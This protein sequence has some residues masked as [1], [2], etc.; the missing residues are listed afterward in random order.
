MSESDAA[1]IP[2]PKRLSLEQTGEW[3][4]QGWEDFV[5]EPVLGLIFGGIYPLVGLGLMA[6]LTLLD[7]GSL[8]LLAASAFML[9]GPVAATALYEIARRR[10][11][12]EPV[13]FGIII[14]S[15]KAR[16]TSIGDLGLVLT[17]IL[18]SWFLIG[19]VLFAMFF[20][21]SPP[22]FSDFIS[23]VLFN[24]ASIPFMLVSTSIGFLLATLVFTISV[25]AMPMLMDRDVTAYDAVSFSIRAVWKNRGNMIGWA[26]TITAFTAFGMS[27]AFVG[28]MVTFPVIAYASWHAYRDVAG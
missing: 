24:P 20:T 6:V 17:M 25:F 27:L 18:L 16:S 21:G 26:A 5:A 28:L 2:V 19:F 3:L 15:V 12:G 7:L 4:R 11:L 22:D 14:Q 23:N 13:S 1:L 8:V 9:V 10:E